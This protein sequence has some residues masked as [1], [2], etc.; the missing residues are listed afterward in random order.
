[1][2]RRQLWA[3]GEGTGDGKAGWDWRI[4]STSGQWATVRRIE[5]VVKPAIDLIHALTIPTLFAS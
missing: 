3:F 1:M 5:R 2:V 4:L